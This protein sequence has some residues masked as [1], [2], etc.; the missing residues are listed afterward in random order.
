MDWGRP[1]G[2]TWLLE[3][4]TYARASMAFT[5]SCATG[6]DWKSGAG[7]CFCL[8]M[9]KGTGSRFYIGMAAVSRAAQVTQSGSFRLAIK[10]G[11]IAF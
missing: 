4:P 3:P 9:P 1:P 10:I 11:S 7:I 8:P 6:S 5:E 2:F